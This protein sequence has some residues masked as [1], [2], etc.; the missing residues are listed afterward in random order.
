ML[1]QRGVGVLQTYI[2]V[3]VENLIYFAIPASFHLATKKYHHHPPHHQVMRSYLILKVKRLHKPSIFPMSQMRP[4]NPKVRGLV[5][6]EMVCGE[7]SWSQD[8]CIKIH[9]P[10]PQDI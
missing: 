1:K 4:G 2:T 7:T 10:Y 3:Y 5:V 8:D 9:H 6:S